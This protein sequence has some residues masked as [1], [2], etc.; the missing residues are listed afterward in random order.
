MKLLRLMLMLPTLLPLSACA[1]SGGPVVGQVLEEGTHKPVPGAIVVVRWR[2][3]LPGFADSRMVC[4][5]VA[6]TITDEAGRYRIP[7]WS[8]EAEK[9]WQRR[10]IDKEF[11][12]VAYK[13]G[14]GLP[15]KPSQKEKI[16]YVAPFNGGVKERFEYLNR[17]ISSTSCVSAGTSYRSLYRIRSAIYEEARAIAQTVDEKRYAETYK[18]LV[19]GILVDETKPTKYDKSGRLI[20][21]NPEDSFKPE[22]LK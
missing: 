5:H 20:N 17:V 18:G 7:A 16:V 4:Y 11:R 22:E 15:A 3:V 19:E 1:L 13:A 12:A 6:S 9:D 8:K 10:I 21:V 14:Y 2:G